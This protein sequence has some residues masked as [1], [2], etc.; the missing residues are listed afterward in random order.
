MD[1][2]EEDFQKLREQMADSRSGPQGLASEIRE[3]GGR[4]VGGRRAEVS[5]NT[6]GLRE[7]ATELVPCDARTMALEL[8]GNSGPVKFGLI[9]LPAT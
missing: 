6:D 4:V 9:A 2:G 3:N 8:S 7:D 1:D 5:A